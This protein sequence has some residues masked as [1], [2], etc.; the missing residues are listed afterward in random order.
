MALLDHYRPST[1][2]ETPEQPR[3]V[4]GWLVGVVVAMAL[5][6]VGVAWFSPGGDGGQGDTRTRDEITK[7]LENLGYIPKPPAATDAGGLDQD[8]A[9]RDLVNRGLIPRETLGGG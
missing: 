3:R 7:E 1:E 4:R 9:V 2:Q 8:A 6:V 5:V